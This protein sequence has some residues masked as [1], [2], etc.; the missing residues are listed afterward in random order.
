M[1]S[2]HLLPWFVLDRLVLQEVAYQTVIKGVGVIIY[3]DKKF[4][5]PPLSLYIDTYFFSNTKHDQEEVAILLLYHFR[6]ERFMMH[7]PKNFIKEHFNKKGMPWEYTLEV[8]E[9][10]EIHCDARNYDEVI[11]KRRGKPIGRISDE[12]REREESRKKKEEE[13]TEKGSIGTTYA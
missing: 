8:W 3:G 7:D 4:I 11:F 10:E 6:E 12:E 2:P 5:W 1:K 9:E 13:A